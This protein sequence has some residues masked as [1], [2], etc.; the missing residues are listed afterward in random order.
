MTK[1]SLLSKSMDLNILKTFQ[2]GMVSTSGFLTTCK[3]AMLCFPG[4]LYFCNKICLIPSLVAHLPAVY[5]IFN[6][7]MIIPHISSIGP[8]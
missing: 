4:P 2:T 8:N 3:I 1:T 5:V 7:D 6:R